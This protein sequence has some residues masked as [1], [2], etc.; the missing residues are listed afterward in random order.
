MLPILLWKDQDVWDFI[1]SRGVAYCS[2]YDEGFKRLG[3]VG[4]P[5]S[6]N[7]PAEFARW[8]GF[9]KAWRLAITRWWERNQGTDKAL[10]RFK[11]PEALWR[12][13]MNEAA[14]TDDDDEEDSCQLA[15]DML[16]GG[17]ET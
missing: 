4:C 6:S 1:R 10:A 8:P 13:W 14:A 3:C 7:R 16:S 9:E 17:T 11:T 2:L 15:L 12:W 5:L